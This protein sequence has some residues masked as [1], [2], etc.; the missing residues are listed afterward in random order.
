[1]TFDVFERDGAFEVVGRLAEK[2]LEGTG[3]G[4]HRLGGGEHASA[5]VEQQRDIG[6]DAARV[7]ANRRANGR[8]I[9]A[10]HRLA[11]HGQCGVAIFGRAKYAGPC[12][13]HGAVAKPLHDSVAKD[14]RA[15][16]VDDGHEQSP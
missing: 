3:G 6:A 4:R 16:L 7:V 2:A 15:G 13:L 8:R 14:V 11:K 12:E 1:M 10:R 9:A 5:C